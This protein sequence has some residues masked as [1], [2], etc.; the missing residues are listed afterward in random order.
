M[1]LYITSP[2]LTRKYEDRPQV[3]PTGGT[4]LALLGQFV[5]IQRDIVSTMEYSVRGAQMAVFE[6]I[7]VQKKV[8]DT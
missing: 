6:M 7:G 3:I 1:M 4:N 2:F 8:K 5:E